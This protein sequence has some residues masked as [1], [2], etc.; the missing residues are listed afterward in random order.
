[1]E[2]KFPR[3]CGPRDGL[4]AYSLKHTNEQLKA[5]VRG[6]LEGP[7]L[8]LSPKLTTF[9]GGQVTPTHWYLLVC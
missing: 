4:S 2:E 9:H 8:N 6:A 7:P 3:L 1:M 5:H